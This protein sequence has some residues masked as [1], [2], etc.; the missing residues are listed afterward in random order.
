MLKLTMKKKRQKTNKKKI[1][2]LVAAYQEKDRLPIFRSED[3]FSNMKK[4]RFTVPQVAVL[5]IL[6]EQSISK[7]IQAD[8]VNKLVDRTPDWLEMEDDERYEAIKATLTLETVAWYLY[9]RNYIQ[10]SCTMYENGFDENGNVILDAFYVKE[11][12]TKNEIESLKQLK[13]KPV[14]KSKEA[15]VIPF[16]KGGA[17]E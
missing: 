12:K 5:K 3:T 11:T 13:E 14:P 8:A 4:V 2:D 15:V 7:E 16:P 10:E 6:E 9:E 1:D 17:K